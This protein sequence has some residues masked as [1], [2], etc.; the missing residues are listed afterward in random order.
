[1]F[2]RGDRQKVSCEIWEGQDKITG[3]VMQIKATGILGPL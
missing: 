2:L 1:M 3:F